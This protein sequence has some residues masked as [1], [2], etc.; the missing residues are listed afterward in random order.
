[1]LQMSQ[2]LYRKNLDN[3]LGVLQ[4]LVDNIEDQEF[5]ESFI[6][7]MLLVEAGRPLTETELDDAA[8]R[9]IN[10]AFNGLE[11]DF[12]VDDALDKITVQLDANGQ[13]QPTQEQLNS[14]M[15]L[16]LVQEVTGDD[17][18]IRY[19]AKPVADALEAMD[20][21]WDNFFQYA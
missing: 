1:M 20:Y 10:E 19:Q 6:A 13:E 3:D 7:Y 11:V 16:P 4:Y 18:E 17:G 2:D 12:E 8:E 21:R 15:F 5:K 14:T 9:F